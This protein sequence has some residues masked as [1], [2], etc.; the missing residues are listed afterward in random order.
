[1]VENV[2]V[3]GLDDHNAGILDRLPD[4]DLA[5]PA[6]KLTRRPSPW[7]RGLTDLPVHFTPTPALGGQK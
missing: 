1:M 2:F 7:L 3:V 4:V 5:V 6:D